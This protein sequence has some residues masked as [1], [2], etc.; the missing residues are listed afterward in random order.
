M[1]SV[2]GQG[3]A[4]MDEKIIRRLEFEAEI[5]RA[6]LAR[7]CSPFLTHEE[8]ANYLCLSARKL[9]SLRSSGAGPL[10]RRH[11]RFVR[12]HI[13]DLDAWSKGLAQ[14]GERDD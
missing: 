8:A 3:A 12:Y 11:S 4:D 2:T 10:V 6:A 13:D 5:G 14:G 1:P 9:L 7:K